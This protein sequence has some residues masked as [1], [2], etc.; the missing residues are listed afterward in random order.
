MQDAQAVPYQ[1]AVQHPLLSLTKTAQ[2]LYLTMREVAFEVSSRRGYK[3]LPTQVAFFVPTEIVAYAL[4]VARSSIYRNLPALRDAGLIDQRGHYTSYNGET[5]SDGSVWA[6]KLNPEGEHQA[7]L[8]H[9]ELKHQYRD[10][11]ADIDEGKT[12]Y[13]AILEMQQSNTEENHKVN[14]EDIILEHVPLPP[15]NF[16]LN[17]LLMTVALASGG[18]LSAVYDVPQVQK[19]DRKQA[20]NLAAEACASYLQDSENLNFYRWLLWRALTLYWQKIDCFDFLVQQICRAGVD[21]REGFARKPAALF[22]S[23]LKKTQVWAQMRSLETQD[24]RLVTKK[25]A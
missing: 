3:Q 21:K 6:V 12:A 14:P 24:V 25:V 4:G 15:S 19:S 23:R 2:R 7:R 13:K 17:P 22:V 1:T 18:D 5:R 9:D 11:A 10:L 20:V 16:S 8:H